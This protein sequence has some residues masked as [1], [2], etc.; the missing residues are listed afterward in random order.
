MPTIHP[1]ALVDPAAAIG[2]GTTIGP[3]CVVGAGV[4]LG[5]DNLLRSHVVVEGPTRLGDG[6]VLHPFAAIG[7]A[8]QDLRYAG[9]PTR[10]EIGD[11]NIF[12]ESV[13]VN[14]GTTNGGGLTTLGSDCLMMAY[15]HV[16]HDCHVGDGVILANCAMLAGHVTIERFAVIGGLTPIHQFAR[17]G[18]YAFVGGATRVT[19]DIVP[20]ARMGGIPPVISGANLIG[21]ARR[22]FT[23]ETVKVIKE[24]IRLLFR[25]GLNTTQ[26][27]A[28]I[29][30]DLPSL[31]E[32][33]HLLA[34][35]TSSKR[36]IQ[37]SDCR[38]AGRG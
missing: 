27:V 28:R 9:D 38:P 36:G 23:P 15:S 11:R 4:V 25:A 33:E 37:K 24:A 20:Y 29:R 30:E 10:L 1:T 13:T 31:P 8:P 16:A 21:L 7:T 3:F 19:Q 35:I 22:G 34:F 17:V 2:D 32:I 5:R 14:R 26:A 18:E 12:R 6:N